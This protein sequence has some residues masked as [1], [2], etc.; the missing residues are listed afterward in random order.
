MEINVLDI[1]CDLNKM[2]ITVECNGTQLSRVFPRGEGWLST[3]DEGVPAFAKEFCERFEELQQTQDVS[4]N[5][6]SFVG[7]SFSATKE[8]SN[9]NVMH[10]NNKP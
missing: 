2:L 9:P 7:E 1:N 4:E 5:P 8:F 10:E 3:D 6:Q